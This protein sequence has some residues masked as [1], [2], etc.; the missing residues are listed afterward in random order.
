MNDQ[1]F[2]REARKHWDDIEQASRDARAVHER[3]LKDRVEGLLQ[4]MAELCES[5]RYRFETD[6]IG[7]DSDNASDWTDAHS[8]MDRLYDEL[9]FLRDAAGHG[10]SI[11]I[12]I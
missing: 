3:C 1:T 2:G 10:T 11:P 9:K 6:Q 7:I 5:I 4:D 8:K 12:G